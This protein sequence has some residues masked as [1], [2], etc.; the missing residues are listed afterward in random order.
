MQCEKRVQEA[1]GN[2]HLA[3]AVLTAQLCTLT[4]TPV[5]ME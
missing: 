1:T 4:G 5:G 2:T 3:Q